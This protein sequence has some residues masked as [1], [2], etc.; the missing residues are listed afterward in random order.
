MIKFRYF[1][2][3][4]VLLYLFFCIYN[5]QVR[6]VRQ[7]NFRLYNGGNLRTQLYPMRLGQ[8]HRVFLSALFVSN[9][10]IGN[11]HFKEMCRNIFRSLFIR[12]LMILQQG[13]GVKSALKT[14]AT[15]LQRGPRLFRARLRVIEIRPVQPL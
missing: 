14:S 7:S 13:H 15:L 6:S 1:F 2:G 11:S 12:K 10:K 8:L 4:K 5:P 3:V 9:F